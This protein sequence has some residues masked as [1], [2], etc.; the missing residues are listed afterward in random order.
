MCEQC[1]RTS[2]QTSEWPS[3]LWFRRWVCVSV[4]PFHYAMSLHHRYVLTCVFQMG[5]TH[6]HAHALVWINDGK[7]GR[8][9]LV[10]ARQLS[11][12][13]F[14]YKAGSM[15]TRGWMVGRENN[16]FAEN[17][18]GPMD[19]FFWKQSWFS[20]MHLVRIMGTLDL[21]FFY[22]NVIFWYSYFSYK[23]VVFCPFPHPLPTPRQNGNTNLKKTTRQNHP[24]SSYFPC[25]S[26][27]NQ[28][29]PDFA[30][31]RVPCLSASDSV[32]L[33]G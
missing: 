3:I 17:S 24:P 18:G 25:L 22:S 32:L 5:H 29:F 28:C 10:L 8:L 19:F 23:M 2:K 33:G 16:H 7:K 1:E 4:S 11:E 20:S 21:T 15:G 6:A 13:D 14:E 27:D 30:T 9:L 12:Y 31:I 26:F